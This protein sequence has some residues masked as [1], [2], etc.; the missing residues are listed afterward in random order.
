MRHGYSVRLAACLLAAVSPLPEASFAYEVPLGEGSVREAYFLGQRNDE[1]TAL[2]LD[3]YRQHLSTPKAGPYI[4]RIE[5]FTP[6]AQVVD[7]SRRRTVGYSAQQAA[8]DYAKQPYLILVR[9]QIEFTETYPYALALQPKPG[10]PIRHS[11]RPATFWKDFRIQLS[12]RG[13]TI[14]PQEA[15]GQLVSRATMRS[16]LVTG[17]SVTLT[18]DA[19]KIASE[20]TLV[21]VFPPE[22]QGVGATFDLAKLR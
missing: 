18:F 15:Q 1:R 22:G 19:D 13:K 21:E 3:S 11:F 6:Y 9:V 8:K 12:Q 14:E 5:L 7:L 10:T 4:S 17:A 16:S 2:F 20:L